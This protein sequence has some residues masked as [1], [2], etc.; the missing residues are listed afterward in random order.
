[1]RNGV[2]ILRFESYL[3]MFSY[4]W[5]PRMLSW[6]LN[7]SREFDIIHTHVFRFSHN[8]YVSL[9]H[10]KNRTPF[11]LTAHDKLKLDYM[12]QLAST[13]DNIYRPTVG[14]FIL[15]MAKRVIA[16][17]Q[18]NKL[19]YN[20]LYNVPFEKIAVIPNG[21]D[22]DYYSHLPKGT[23]LL[24]T[25]SNP[26]QVIL[27]LGRFIDYKR[28]DLLIKSFKMVLMHLPT[29][30]LLMVGKDFGL[31]HYCRVLVKDLQLER[32]V[33]FIENASEST[34]LEAL[35]I[36]DVCV[37]PSIHETYPMVALEAAAAGVP[38]IALNNGGLG[39]IVANG[40]TGI[41]MDKMECADLANEIIAL[42]TN[43]S[44]L[45]EMGKNSKLFAK[46]FS[47]LNVTEK[48]EAIYKEVL[49]KI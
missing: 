40:K 32:K 49:N 15:K 33:T 29:S 45:S 38:V 1:M 17:Y 6:L 26:D 41:L 3:Q 5:S 19:E 12:G 30:H 18:L 28:P 47:W 14:K 16:L 48:I 22:A 11:V 42:I 7:N 25:L 27:F 43:P 37:I 31:V 23:E 39:D 44:K 2:R 20:A 34:K 35:S 10:L 9:A 13:I 8:E 36:A 4:Y 24:Q 21:I 46:N